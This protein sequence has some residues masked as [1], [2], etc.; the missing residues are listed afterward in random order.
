MSLLLISLPAGPPG[1]YDFATSRDG[2]GLHA[3]GSALPGLL[4]PA[5]RGVEV[6]AMVPPALLSWHKVQL[7]KGIG[8]GSPRLR[9]TLA[10]LLEEHLLDDADQLHFALEPGAGSAGSVW[11]AVCNRPWLSAHMHALDAAG[12]TVNRIVPELSPRTGPLRLIVAGVP[13]RAQLLISGDAV[14]GGV[15]ALPLGPGSLSLLPQPTDDASQEAELLTE[16][17]VAALA[18]QT[19]GRQL[20]IQQAPERMLEATRSSWDLA[21]FDFSQGGRARAA[22]RA[23]AVWR[24]LMYAPAWRPARWGVALLLLAQIVGLNWLAWQTRADLAARRSQIEAAL[25][26]TFPQVKVVVDAPVQM[27]RE[28]AALRQASGAFSASDLEPA[29]SAFALVAPAG[30]APSAIEFSA[31]ELRARGVQMAASALSEAN[32]RLRPL[33]YQMQTEANAVVLKPEGAP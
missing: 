3:H 27:A 9:A 1:N 13:E 31:G 18:E 10:G 28:V 2:Q 6:V 23:G 22:K 5:G 15:Q 8:P 19:L 14:P 33:G 17:A 29:L 11:V 12:R 4:P 24:D 7:P 26:Q 20:T 16:P 21:Q 30:S 25:T 32:Q